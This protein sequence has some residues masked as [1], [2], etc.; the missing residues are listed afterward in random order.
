M[1][2]VPAPGRFELRLPDGA[3]NP[4]LLQ[5]VIIAAGID[6]IKNRTNPGNASILICTLIVKKLSVKKL[7]L[8]LLDALRVFERNKILKLSLGEEFSKAYISL[9]ED[10]WNHTPRIFLPGKRKYDRRMIRSILYK[11][12]KNCEYCRF[13]CPKHFLPYKWN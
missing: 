8:N 9:K 11:L 10:E 7:P 3:A 5:A 13:V 4:Y 12:L 2:R 1:V 6:G